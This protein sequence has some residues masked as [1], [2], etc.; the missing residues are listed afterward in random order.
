MVKGFKPENQVSGRVMV[1]AF[2][3]VILALEIIRE[4]VHRF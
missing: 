4:L 1:A 2:A 3:A